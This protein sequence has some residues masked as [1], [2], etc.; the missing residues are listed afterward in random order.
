MGANR[1][2]WNGHSAR[3][4]HVLFGEVSNIKIMGNKL[5]EHVP[6][7][8]TGFP[9]PNPPEILLRERGREK[10]EG[11]LESQLKSRTPAWVWQR[12]RERE[13]G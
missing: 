6:S 4:N 5:P 1:E 12:G 13:K 3:T 8:T 7:P 9:N 2:A 11:G 10:K